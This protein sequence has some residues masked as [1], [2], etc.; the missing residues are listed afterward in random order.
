M[1]ADGPPIGPCMQIRTVLY[2]IG[3][4]RLKTA[5]NDIVAGA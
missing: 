2:H 1:L 3:S 4:G 5:R